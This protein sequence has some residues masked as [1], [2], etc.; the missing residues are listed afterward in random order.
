L[1]ALDLVHPLTMMYTSETLPFLILRK[2]SPVS[3]LE[4]PESIRRPVNSYNVVMGF[5]LANILKDH[6]GRFLVD[7]IEEF[8]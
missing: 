5:D 4:T 2:S 1:A 6:A 8:F 3:P 7:F